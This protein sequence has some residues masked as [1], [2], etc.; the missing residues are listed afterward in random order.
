MRRKSILLSA[1][2]TMVVLA[3]CGSVWAFS[4]SGSGMEADPYVIT[5]VQQLQEMQDELDA[6]YVLGNDIDASETVNWDGGAGFVPVGTWTGDSNDAFSGT[7]D[8]MGHSIQSLYISRIDSGYQ[9]L[10]GSLWGGTVQDV[11]LRNTEITAD[12]KSGTLT[13]TARADSIIT[14]CSATGT[15][16]LKA[17]TSDSKSGGLIGSVTGGSQVQ[18]CFSGVNVNAGSRKQVGAV[19]GYLAGRTHYTLLTNS[20]SYGT[21]TGGGSKQG[22]LVGDADGS[23]VDRCYSCGYEK[24]LIGFNWANPVI[25]NSY[26]DKDKGASSSRYGGTPKSTAEMMQQA[27]FVNWDFVDIWGILENGVYP[28]LIAF[29][30][31]EFVGLEIIGPREVAENFSA[32]YKAIAFY[33]DD[34]TRD[35]TN[36]ALWAVEP[37]IAANIDEKGVLTTKDVTEEQSVTILTSYSEGD[38]TFDADKV[39]N[40]FPA[41]PGAALYFDGVDDYVEIPDSDSLNPTNEI[42]ISFWVYHN[43]CAGIYKY[44]FC[45]NQRYSPGNSRSY[46][47]IVNNGTNQVVLRIHSTASTGD[48]F[49]SNNAVGLNEWHHVTGTF[50]RGKAEIYIDGE[51]DN[52]T[53]MSVSSIMDDDHPL[54]IGGL[55]SYCGADHWVSGLVGI[56]DEV[57][58]YNRALSAEEIQARISRH[59]TGEEPGLVGYWDFDEGQGQ[60]VYDLSGNGNHGCLG[61]DPCAVEESDPMWIESD[62]P[63]GI[64]S[65]YQIATVFTGNAVERKTALLEELPAVLD[66]E[67]TV[68]EALVEWLESGD[69]GDLNYGDI[70][71]AKQKIHS[72]IQHEEQS[73]LALEQSVEKLKDAL[74]SL[75]Y[76]LPVSNQSVLATGGLEWTEPV[77]LME[78]NSELATEWTPFLSFD[79]LTLYFTRVRSETFYYGRIFEAI[80]EQPYGPFTPVKE[81]DGT[82]NSS[83]GHV[84]SPWVSPDN[85]RMYYY[86]ESSSGWELKVTER[87]TDNDPWPIGTN[88]SELNVLNGLHQ[89]PRLTADELTIF[90]SSYDMPGGYGGYDIWMATRPDR[91]SPFGQVTNLA[92]INT[93][94]FDHAPFVSPDGLTLYFDSNRNGKNQLF[95][96]SRR[97]L[98]EQFGNVEHLSFV[99]MPEGAGAHP[100][101]SSDGRTIYFVSMANIWVSYRLEPYELAVIL[102]EDAIARKVEVLEKINAELEKELA[103]YEAL[104]E[105]FE[106]G[107]YGHLYKGDIVTAKQKIYSA[108]QHEEQSIDAL[109]K[110]IEK[111]KDALSALGYDPAGQASNPNPAD[112]SIDVD[113]DADLSWTA[114]SNAVS[115]DIYFGTA[116]PPQFIGNQTA[117]TFDPGTMVGN[118]RYYW[119]IDEVNPSWTTTGTVWTFTTILPPPPPPP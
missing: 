116:N 39:V 7:F 77:P 62:A 81:I 94:S 118:M 36:L 68:Y 45:P 50:N 18:E 21:V 53:T 105:W 96:A 4:G 11:H 3:F 8:G 119:R 10:F 84:I 28:F 49:Y 23:Y 71:T 87:A 67:W 57:A 69:Y 46:Y 79:G 5:T 78:V 58:I 100:C 37:N 14:K 89:T 112:G 2:A 13:G 22:N 106:S 98:S 63:I 6:Y 90:F 1:T 80:R 33:D 24:A 110:S 70:V 44:A 65:F 95:R 115:H 109:E 30:Y 104:E 107:Y 114:G 86:T 26:W 40:I 47:L 32:G 20:Y 12:L 15:V 108:I 83:P 113:I 92:E 42:T 29:E 75:G 76:E 51:L 19:I 16:T 103:A 99:D 72:A 60:V 102:T 61:G 66:Q 41:F 117:A 48:S 34:R 38:V 82:L 56:I 55:W 25:T 85:L 35:V 97:S 101:V 17:G 9:G 54:F 111:L 91:Y 52:S 31:K 64:C 73:I 59:L 27:T 43:G 93:A 74:S 88:I